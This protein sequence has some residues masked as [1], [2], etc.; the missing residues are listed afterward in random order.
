MKG[1]LTPVVLAIGVLGVHGPAAAQWYPAYRAPVVYYYS[2]IPYYA[3]PYYWYSA[4]ALNYQ[5]AVYWNSLA[6]RNYQEAYRLA[7]ENR[8]K[9]VE[10]YFHNKA[11][12]E[13][14]RSAR[15][16]KPLTHEQ[17]VE[18]ARKQ[19]PDRLTE[20]QY[21]RVLGKLRWPYVLLD[22]DFTPERDAV[23]R[24]FQ[25]RLPEDYG[26]TTEFYNQVRRLAGRLEL[27][28]RDKIALLS[29]AEY[30]AA[31]NFVLSLA[32]EAQKPPTEIVP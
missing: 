26:P 14:F 27:K 2:P 21:D 31:K 23:T 3:P 22:D 15:R 19:A 12:N 30:M 25:N 10:T 8:E 5:R 16:P 4:A 32:Y 9:M 18:L 7:L 6:A 13:Q 28:L 1:A 11:L 24:L 29:P 20:K 17:Y